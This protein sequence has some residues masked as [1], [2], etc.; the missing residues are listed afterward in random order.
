MAFQGSRRD[1]WA[2]IR[3]QTLQLTKGCS[4]EAAHLGWGVYLRFK[5]TPPLA[6]VELTLHR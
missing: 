1:I 3:R 2:R 6:E 4:Q 5:L